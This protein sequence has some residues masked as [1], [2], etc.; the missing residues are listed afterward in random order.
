MSSMKHIFQSI[1]KEHRNWIIIVFKERFNVDRGVITALAAMA[2]TQDP[3]VRHL[4][5]PCHGKLSS[6]V[7]IVSFLKHS[8]KDKMN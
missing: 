3:P 7:T 1:E 6:C 2:V 5:S 4:H 8:G